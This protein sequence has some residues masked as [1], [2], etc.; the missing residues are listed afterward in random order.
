MT[1]LKHINILVQP[2]HREKLRQIARA[3]SV[4]EGSQVS[5]SSIVRQL[6]ERYL[7]GEPCESAVCLCGQAE[8]PFSID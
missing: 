5:I 3:L 4:Q 7:A 8:H 6:I 2:E 1:K